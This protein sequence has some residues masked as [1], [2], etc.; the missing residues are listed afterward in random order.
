MAYAALCLAPPAPGEPASGGRNVTIQK[1]CIFLLQG[2]RNCLTPSST[3]TK[4][5]QRHSHDFPGRSMTSV[6][7][8]SREPKCAQR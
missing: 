6:F 2:A 8:I 1:F 3:V 5:L 4:M 7:V